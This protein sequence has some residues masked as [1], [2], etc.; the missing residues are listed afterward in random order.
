MH[1]TE[2]RIKTNTVQHQKVLNLSLKMITELKTLNSK[3]NIFHMEII[4]TRTPWPYS[5]KMCQR[6]TH[7]IIAGHNTFATRIS[8][9]V[10]DTTCKHFRFFAADQ[11]D[12]LWTD[13]GKKRT[14]N[15]LLKI[16]IS[17][18]PI[19]YSFA[20]CWVWC[21]IEWNGMDRKM[22]KRNWNTSIEPYFHCFFL[23]V[24]IGIFFCIQCGTQNCRLVTMCEMNDAKS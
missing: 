4:C 21:G 13:G 20:H 12:R 24:F 3:L 22:L 2:H 6:Q 18:W 14:N 16:I 7:H 23:S 17:L 8:F 10:H 11:R 15:K 5:A 9:L 19:S 1:W